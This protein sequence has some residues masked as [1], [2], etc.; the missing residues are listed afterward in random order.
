MMG[1]VFKRNEPVRRGPGDP[2]RDRR[3]PAETIRSEP[4]ASARVIFV[5]RERVGLGA[6]I[7]PTFRLD[8]SAKFVSA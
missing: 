4:D 2:R 1:S 5:R 8:H 7:A 6:D 3:A